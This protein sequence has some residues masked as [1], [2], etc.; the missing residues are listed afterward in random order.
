MK[1][2]LYIIMATTLLAFITTTTASAQEVFGQDA[3]PSSMNPVEMGYDDLPEQVRSVAESPEFNHLELDKVYKVG[4]R[5]DLHPDHYTIRFKN[6]NTYED[7]YVDA[8]GNIIDPQ[9]EKDK[10]IEP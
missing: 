2:L 6:N 8:E 9:D 3:Q 1:N 5:N 7:V 4:E 10:T